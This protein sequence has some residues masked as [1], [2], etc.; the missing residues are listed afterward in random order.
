LNLFVILIPIFFESP[1]LLYLLGIVPIQALLLWA[2]WRWRQQ[3]LRRLGSPA[4][5]ARLLQGFSSRRFWVKNTMFGLGIV[6]VILALASPVRIEKKESTTQRSADILLALDISNSMLAKDVSPS[7]LDQAKDFI[8]RL[9]PMLTGERVGLVFFA[10]EAFPQMPLSTDMEALLMF[11]RNAQPDFITDQGTDIGAAVELCKRMLETDAATG[12]A[13]ILLSD[14]ENHEEK[15][16]QRVR[17]AKEAGIV[18]YT[19]GVGAATGSNLPKSKGGIQVDGMGKPVRS[20]ANETLLQS[21]AQAGG[22][23]ALNLRDPERA[24]SVL[25][26]AISQLQ[27]SAITLNAKTEKV[28]LFPWLLL[29]A[30]LLLIAEQVMWWKKTGI[31]TTLFLLFSGFLSAQSEHGILRQGEQLYDRGEYEKA[32]TVYQKSTSPDARYNAGNAAYL[33]SDYDLSAQLYREAAE[34][35][36]LP[37]EKADAWYNLGNTCLLKGDYQ[38]AVEAYERSLRLV[39][40]RPDAQKNLQIA[41]RKLQA[42]PPDAPPPP[43]PPPPPTVRPRQNYLDQATSSRHAERPP[44]Y[45]SPDDAR[46]LLDK[47]VLSEEQK[48]AGTYRELA[49][50]NRPSRLKKD[51]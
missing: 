20:A 3:T 30:L 10:G 33:H 4:L 1:D 15:V 28:Y 21:L 25:K 38:E 39:P 45:L 41:K 13:I 23:A 12:R 34:K 11:T 5:E 2:Y 37:T 51:W 8:Q 26:N 31:T 16:L 18:L 48:N 29:L 46:R 9:A 42:P 14:G 17:E 27:K 32:K 19:V 7:R 36:I 43:P 50:A 6:L 47:A 40:K 35:S 24:V 49:P 44:A 22:G